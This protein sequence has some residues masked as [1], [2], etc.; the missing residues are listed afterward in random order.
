MREDYHRGWLKMDELDQVSRD[1]PSFTPAL[2]GE[3][4]QSVLAAVHQLYEGS[5]T[6]DGLLGGSDLHSTEFMGK[7]YGLPAAGPGM[8]TVAADPAQRWGILTHPALMAF[9]AH[10][11]TSDPIKRGVFIAEELLCQSIPDP[12]PDIPELPPLRPGLSTR[13]RLAQHRADPACAACHDRLDPVGLAFEHYDAIGRYRTM[14]Q[15]V[16]VD[17]SADVSLGLDLDGKYA[18]GMEL[19]R[20]LPGSAA[21]RDCM[22]R[23]W[24]EY[25]VSRPEAAADACALD[26]VRERFRK[27]GDLVG[28]LAAISES[29]AFRYEQVP[30]E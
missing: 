7:V 4:R 21:V 12:Q 16:P 3:L 17:S 20:K 27:D 11:D 10:A 6:V 23:R 24:F 29:E 15:G 22:A 2:A 25:A 1:V 13:Q 26:R 18:T 30:Q 19:I 5:P 9:L 8:A 28:L 14:D